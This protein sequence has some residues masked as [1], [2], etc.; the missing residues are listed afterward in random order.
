MTRIGNERAGRD[1]G[2]AA[3]TTAVHDGCPHESWWNDRQAEVLSPGPV[4]LGHPWARLL[5]RTRRREPRPVDPPEHPIRPEVVGGH[6]R[7]DHEERRDAEHD[8]RHH[9]YLES[10]RY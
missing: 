8:R 3:G 10:S 2:A 7:E 4:G 1:A 6:G 5:P 9:G